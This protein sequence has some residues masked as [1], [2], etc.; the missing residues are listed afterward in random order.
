MIQNVALIISSPRPVI[1]SDRV[2]KVIS[3]PTTM[4]P[5]TGFELLWSNA[6]PTE[7]PGA[8]AKN[9]MYI[10]GKN[11]FVQDFIT[12]YNWRL[13]NVVF[14]INFSAIM[15]DFDRRPA[16]SKI[17]ATIPDGRGRGKSP[18]YINHMGSALF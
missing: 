2:G 1:L 18:Q 12:N 15:T 11:L 10:D 13:S 14:K 4:C 8:L 6:L 7:L 9:V 17:S 16:Q 3:Y 5:V